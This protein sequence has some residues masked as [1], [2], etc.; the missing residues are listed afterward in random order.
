MLTKHRERYTRVTTDNVKNQNNTIEYL[1]TKTFTACGKYNCGE[2]NE[3][4]NDSSL[5]A[6]KFNRARLNPWLRS[7]YQHKSIF[8][9]FNDLS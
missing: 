9:H 3:Q 5:K 2:Q 6:H 7:L 8:K 4:M 1:T